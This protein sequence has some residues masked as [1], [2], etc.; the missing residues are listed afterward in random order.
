M[1]ISDLFPTRAN[2]QTHLRCNFHETLGNFPIPILSKI[3][4]DINYLVKMFEISM[5]NVYAGKVK[6]SITSSWAFFDTSSK[7]V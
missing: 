3:P 5:S 1:V 6:T 7:R 4:V 2:K